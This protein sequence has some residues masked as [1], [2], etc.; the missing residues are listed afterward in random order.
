MKKILVML[1]AVALLF[2][3]CSLSF[4]NSFASEDTVLVESDHGFSFLVPASWQALEPGDDTAF[5]RYYYQTAEA[6]LSLLIFSELGTMG[7]YSL[8]EIGAALSADLQ[9][10]L[11]GSETEKPVVA[12]S[13]DTFYRTKITGYDADG[14][15]LISEIAIFAPYASIRYQ[16]IFTAS[17]PAYL[18]NEK[19]IDG[20]IGSF[21]L[22]KSEEDLY[23]LVQELHE[24][25]AAAEMEELANSQNSDADTSSNDEDNSNDPENE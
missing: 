9:Q 18:E 11:F 4:E 13:T 1:L 19:N 12:A 24:A 17:G 16:M 3:G 22:I 23:K 7:Y 21:Q 15:Q 5:Q 20:I 6:D 10:S 2:T 25:A 14:Q 8:E